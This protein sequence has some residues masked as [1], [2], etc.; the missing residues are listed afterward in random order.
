M[1]VK[2]RKACEVLGV[3]YHRLMSHLRAGHIPAPQKDS[4]GAYWR[5]DEDLERVR[6]SLAIDRR[7][8]VPGA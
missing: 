7:R 3:R 1:G 2:T 8:K 4:S 5:S 6:K